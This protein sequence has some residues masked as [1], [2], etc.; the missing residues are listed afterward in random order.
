MSVNYQACLFSGHAVAGMTAYASYF[1]SD[2]KLKMETC[3][4]LTSFFARQK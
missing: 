2:K 3:D 1:Y 4:I